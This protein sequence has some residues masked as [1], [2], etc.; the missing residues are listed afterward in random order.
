MAF[1]KLYDTFAAAV[2][3]IPDGA[4]LLVGGAS[5]EGQSDGL[6]AALAAAGVKG[7]T[8]VCDLADWP[9]GGAMGALVGAGQVA[10]IITPDPVPRSGDDSIRRGAAAGGTELEALPRGVLAERL[11]A[12]GAGIGGV[13]VPAAP[14]GTGPGGTGPGGTGAPFE[15]GKETRVIAGVPCVLEAPLFADFAFLRAHRAD[16]LGN[17]TY[18]GAQ[19]GWNQVMA[20]AARITIAEVDHIGEPGSIDPELVITPGIF[21]NRLVRARR[22]AAS[23]RD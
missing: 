22:A 7:L 18:R 8:C 23:G 12:A 14:V 20:T 16:T 19:R 21:V 4:T 17:L 15:E 13:F 6:L 5:P 10:R 3:D 9:G 11:R 1:R 2:A